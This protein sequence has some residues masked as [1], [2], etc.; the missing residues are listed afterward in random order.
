[1]VYYCRVLKI[2]KVNPKFHVRRCALSRTYLYRLAVLETTNTD[3]KA[4]EERLNEYKKK[5]KQKNIDDDEINSLFTG[6]LHNLNPFD[7]EFLTKIR[8]KRKEQFLNNINNHSHHKLI[9]FREPFDYKLFE[10][11]VKICS[12]QH[13]F[14]AF[15][16][17]KG[18][19]DMI[20]HRRNP[21]KTAK[22]GKLKHC[23]EGG[24]GP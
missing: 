6:P 3:W 18:R 8:Y 7:Q 4:R 13:N 20:E 2:Q 12:G 1:M 21:V 24:E 14:S 9:A 15:T 16:T 23:G 10:E 5:F 19:I 17:K 11:A 22:I